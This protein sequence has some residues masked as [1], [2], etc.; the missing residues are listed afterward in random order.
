VADRDPQIGIETI[1]GLCAQ[2]HRAPLAGP[3]RVALVPEADRMCRGQAESANSFLKTLEEPPASSI[4]LLTSS[5][6]EGL[7]ETIVSRVQPVRFRR[8][9]E[10]AIRASLERR[11]RHSAEAL[12]LAAALADGSLGRA[13]ELLDGDLN[14]WRQWVVQ[15]VGAFGPRDCPR[16]GLALWRLAEEEGKRLFAQ[17]QARDS[18]ADA[19]PGAEEAEEEAGTE[20][21]EEVRKTEAGWS[22][23]VFGRLLD[24]CEV[25]FR[26]ALVCA[27]AGE[28]APLLQPDSA[29]MSRALSGRFGMEGCEQVLRSLEEARGALRLYIRGDLVGRVL[30]GRMVLALGR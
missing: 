15:G 22:R 25:V 24:L 13:Q 30:A 2:L 16:F 5:R 4:I 1:Q 18:G 28:G 26:D 3:R 12:A 19:G 14:R 27:A 9:A 11:G 17:E 21:A 29:E 23:H 8:L 7:L 20:A 6:P 10:S